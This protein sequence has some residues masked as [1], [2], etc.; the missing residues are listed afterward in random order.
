MAMDDH[1]P[2]PNRSADYSRRLHSEIA[3]TRRL[4]ALIARPGQ[5]VNLLLLFFFSAAWIRDFL[6]WIPKDAFGTGLDYWTYTGWLIDY[7]QGFIRRG[8]SGEIWRLVPAAI[9]PLEF[10]AVF[11]WVLILVVAFSYVRFLARFWKDYHPL[12]LFGLLFLP[13]L[14]M[15]Y[16]HDHGGIARQ[17]ILGYLTVIL[18]LVIIEKTLPLGGGPGLSDADMKR[19]LLWLIPVAVILLPVLILVHE[20][21]FLLFVPLH[22]MITLTIL[23]MK[24]PRGFVRA[25]LWAGL[26]YLPAAVAFG[27]VYLSGTPGYP[28]LLGICNKWAAAGALREST[29]VLPPDKLSGSTL[30]G[31]FN[32]MQW[33]LGIAAKIT[34]MI[35]S[36]K[37][38][39]WLEILPVLGI[40]LW[41][42]VRQ[43]LYSILLAQ[44]VQAFHPQTAKRSIGAFFGKYFIIPLVLSLPIYLTAYD[45]GRWLTV[46][47]INFAM[48]AVSANLPWR[49]YLLR[50]K[51]SDEVCSRADCPKHLDGR[52][53]F[54]IVSTAILILALVLWLPHYCLFSCEI[55]R[56]PLE[57]F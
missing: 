43:G 20:G 13:S 27:A 34:F 22:G 2:N 11:S 19:Y 8:L 28:A 16:I 25:A 26:L 4:Q 47:G 17:E 5:I 37:W 3:L 41:Y 18:H 56:S 44:P 15:F 29:C 24:M 10:V 46:T 52:W 55:V 49:E 38:V 54:T 45:Y 30:P 21:Y 39:A 50:I 57:F 33:T 40:C 6:Y 14:F 31:G 53:G 9:P 36:M 35:I 12:T 32:P 42:L 51:E 23:R 1:N 48:L 7:S